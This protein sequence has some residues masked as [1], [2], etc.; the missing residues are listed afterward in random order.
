MSDNDKAK[1]QLISELAGL[2]QRVAELEASEAEHRRVKEALAQGQHLLRTILDN[3]PDYIYFKDTESR[4]IRTSKAH[5][6]TFGLSD[7]AEAIGKT[8]FDFFSEVHARQAYEDEQEIVRTGR[9]LLNIEE[10]ETWPD[11]PDTFVLT[12]K[13]PLRDEGGKI[14][15]TFGITKDITERKQA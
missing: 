1:E 6:E 4:F 14:I 10:R 8:D 2:R 3:V 11:R 9:P 13:M 7:P 15:G 12:S 5:A